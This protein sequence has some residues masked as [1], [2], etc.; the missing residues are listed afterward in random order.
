MTC[1]YPK[2]GVISGAV[3]STYVEY[4]TWDDVASC[5]TDY[6]MVAFSM[7]AQ[8]DQGLFEDDTATNSLK[9]KCRGPGIDGGDIVVLEG[10]GGG[11]GSWGVWSSECDA[12]TSICSI[13][14]NMHACC[15]VDDT[16]INDARFECCLF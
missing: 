8:S 3:T 16:T 15:N 4:G 2:D 14:V 11:T 7:R 9:F 12:G 1:T 6:Y 10:V 13:A 5:P